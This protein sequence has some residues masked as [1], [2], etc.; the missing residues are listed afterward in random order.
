MLKFLIASLVLIILNL[1]F[2]WYALRKWKNY[3]EKFF[4]YNRLVSENLLL[5]KKIEEKLSYEELL[6]YAKMKGFKDISHEDIKGFLK[7]YQPKSR[8]E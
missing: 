4:L 3:T 1:T 6:R 5:S 2:S 7:I 8:S